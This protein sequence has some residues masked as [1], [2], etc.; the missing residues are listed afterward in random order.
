MRFFRIAGQQR[1]SLSEALSRNM[2]GPVY[3][4]TS[5]ESRSK[6]EE[7]GFK[8]VEE[9]GRVNGYDANSVYLQQTGTPPP[10]HHLGY[11]IYFTEKKQIAKD[12]AGGT[13]RGMKPYYIDAPGM[14]QINFGGVSTM[15]AW[16]KKNGYDYDQLVKNGMKPDEARIEATRHLTQNLSRYGAVY[17]RGRGMYKLL[18]G[19][20]ICVYDPSIIYEIDEK[21]S[22][23]RLEPGAKVKRKSDGMIGI[24]KDIRSAEG[25]FSLWEEKHPGESHPWLRPGTKLILGVKWKKGGSDFNVQ[26][27]DVDPVAI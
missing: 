21:T 1:I 17:F 5:A 19:N 25:I 2:F 22:S 16:W 20:Q 27:V 26:D 10:I 3:H 9:E 14:I 7:Q 13:T 15:M 11:G 24:I 6:I 8:V 4:G 18:D 23:G 12:F